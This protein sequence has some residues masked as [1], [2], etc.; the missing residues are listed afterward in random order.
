MRRIP[1]EGYVWPS[2]LTP[3]TSAVQEC[4]E[5][6]PSGLGSFP[7]VMKNSPVW[8]LVLEGCGPKWPQSSVPTPLAWFQ[9]PHLG[10]KSHTPPPVTILH[11]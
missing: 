8:E 2:T 1:G 6:A 5:Q 4:G 9:G 11:S 10:E 7:H 3:L